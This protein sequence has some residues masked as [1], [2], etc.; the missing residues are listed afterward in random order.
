MC[1]SV[2]HNYTLVVR[3]TLSLTLCLSL[4]LYTLVVM[5]A[6]FAYKPWHLGL[7]IPGYGRAKASVGKDQP[8]NKFRGDKV[9][10]GIRY[11]LIGENVTDHTDGYNAAK[12]AA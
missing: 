5:C 4:C 9:V 1:H 6:V 3:D 7:G 8:D 10:A 12:C 2:A 11:V